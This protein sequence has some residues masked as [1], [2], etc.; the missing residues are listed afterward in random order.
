MTV[1]DRELPGLDVTS[2]FH[3]ARGLFSPEEV[4]ELRGAF[5]AVNADGAVPGLS[6][7]V[8]GRGEYTPDDP[9]AFYPR[10]M[11]PHYHPELPVG[12]LA[13]RYMLDPRLHPYLSAFFEDE[14]VA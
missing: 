14:P 2:G 1:A 12:P 8:G 10:M 9:L 5:M 3:V 13:K 4:A 6:E 11:Q 7:I